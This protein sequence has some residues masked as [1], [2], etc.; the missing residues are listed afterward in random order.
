MVRNTEHT[1]GTFAEPNDAR[2]I[3][4]I[5]EL[6]SKGYLNQILI[7]TDTWNKTDRCT[8]G[9]WGYA[10]ILRDVLPVM[11]AKGMTDEEI[12]TIMVDNPKRLLSFV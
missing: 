7:S 5:M 10:H 11:R 12:H 8:Y 1:F 3:N 2:R 9:G 4:E 6:I